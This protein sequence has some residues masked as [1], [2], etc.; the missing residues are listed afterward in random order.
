MFYVNNWAQSK[1]SFSLLLLKLMHNDK[2]KSDRFTVLNVY[3]IFMINEVCDFKQT[4][5]Y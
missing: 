4:T 3:S 5:I 2:N 1:V